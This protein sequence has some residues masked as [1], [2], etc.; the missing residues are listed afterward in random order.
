MMPSSMAR[1]R[2]QPKRVFKRV[3]QSKPHSRDAAFGPYRTLIEKFYIEEERPLKWIMDHLKNEYE[4][5]S[6]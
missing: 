5:N 1:P 4:F 6:S 2:S 3:P